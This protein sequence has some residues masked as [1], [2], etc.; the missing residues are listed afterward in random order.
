MVGAGTLRLML[1]TVGILTL[2]VGVMATVTACSEAGSADPSTTQTSLTSLPPAPSSTTVTPDDTVGST[3]TTFSDVGLG[4][5]V[6]AVVAR[7][8][9]GP[10]DTLVVLLDRDSYTTLSDIDLENVI[11]DV[12]ERFPPVFELHVVDS[13]AAAELV[14][15]ADVD[16]E[17]LPILDEHYF[18]RLEEGFRIIYLGPY[19]SF[20]ESIL[21]S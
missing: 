9:G 2:A 10:G 6:Y 13:E 8:E 20:G 15:A 16:P 17:L 1:R 11:V 14:L 5:P 21:G 19:E 12:V 4:L 3:T 7:V 18:V